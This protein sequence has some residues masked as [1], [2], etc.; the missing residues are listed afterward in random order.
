MLTVRLYLRPILIFFIFIVIS[1]SNNDNNPLIGPIDREDVQPPGQP[2]P[3]TLSNVG[4]GEISISWLQNTD[5]DLAGYRLYRS[6]DE[7]LLSNFILIFDSPDTTFQDRN[8]NYSTLYFYRVAAYD[9]SNNESVFSESAS[10]I[11]QNTL[12]PSVPE[13]FSVIGQN[14][15]SPLIELSWNESP[16]SDV[17]TYWIFRST[18]SNFTADESTLLDSSGIPLYFDTEIL[19][20]VHYYYKIQAVDRGGLQSAQ[21]NTD[22]DIALFK[23]ELLAPINELLIVPPPIFSWLPVENTVQY[24][25]FVQTAPDTVAIWNETVGNTQISVLYAGST[26]LEPGNLYFWKIA[27]ITKDPVRLNS[28]SVTQQFRIQ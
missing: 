12:P 15:S 27:T 24:K 18:E 7:G 14:I 25:I 17:A 9:S 11:P 4:N 26:V 6:E 5:P 8:L 20:N 13:N 22:T 16:E 1:C 19:V 28:L 3:P 23:T 10:G 2:D 21:S